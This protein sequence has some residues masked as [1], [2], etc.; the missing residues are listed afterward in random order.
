M[1]GTTPPAA[2]AAEPYDFAA[3]G[4]EARRLRKLPSRSVDRFD[5][6]ELAAV[7]P[8]PDVALT[9]PPAASADARNHGRDRRYAAEDVPEDRIRAAALAATDR[10]R[11]AV[12]R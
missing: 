6:P 10:V 2:K 8:K 4:P 7:L 12:R 1:K 9:E 3:A 5:A 11:V